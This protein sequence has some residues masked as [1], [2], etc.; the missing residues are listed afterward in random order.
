MKHGISQRKLGRMPSHRLALLRNLVT[1]LLHHEAIKTTLPKAKEAAKMAEKG[2]NPAKSKAQAYLMPPHHAPPSAYVPSPSNRTHTLPP[3]D[4]PKL[5]TS[6]PPTSLFPKLFNT[7]AKRYA[8]R[9]GGYTRIHRFGHRPG[10]NAPHA[11]LTLVDG[12]RDL[13]YEMMAR[14]VGKESL[15]VHDDVSTGRIKEPGNDWED[16]DERTRSEVR[17]V[18]RY[19]SEEDVKKFKEKAQHFKDTLLCRKK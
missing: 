9:P 13:K 17:K 3:L 12:P 18:L 5:D 8:D 14:A 16:L 6:I 1:A 4:Y 10:D 19:R 7:L 2:T 11:I 15:R